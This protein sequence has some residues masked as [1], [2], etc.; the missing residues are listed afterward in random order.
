MAHQE[1]QLKRI[2]IESFVLVEDSH[3]RLPSI[4]RRSGRLPST[5]VQQHH[6]LYQHQRTFIYHGPQISTVRL[7]VITSNEVAQL[8][9]T[10]VKEPSIASNEVA[11]NYGGLGKEPVITSDEAANYY[12]G[13]V[14]VEHGRK[15]QYR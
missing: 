11:Q 13:F 9:G 10:M 1:D 14:I 2:G 5:Q 6:H 15:K 7:P 12:G 8:Y 3:G 4:T